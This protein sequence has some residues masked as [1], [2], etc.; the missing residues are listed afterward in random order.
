MGFFFTWLSIS[1]AVQ[2]FISRSTICQLLTLVLCQMESQS[3]SPF[4]FLYHCLFNFIFSTQVFHH[5]G[6]SWC[7]RSQIQFYLHLHSSSCRHPVFPAPFV[8]GALFPAYNFRVLVNIMWLKLYMLM[9]ES[10]ILLHWTTCLLLYQCL[11][12]D[13]FCFYYYGSVVYFE[14]WNDLPSNIVCSSPLFWL[15]E[16]FCAS[17][18]ILGIFFSISVKNKI[19]ISIEI[20]LNL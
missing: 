17:I 7:G 13:N 2:F 10:L 8:K 6:V 11:F 3:R 5:F 20:A 19:G 18:W 15:Y 16:A 14:I 9:F 1:L 12:W 4:L